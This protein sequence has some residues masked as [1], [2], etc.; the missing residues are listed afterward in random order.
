MGLLTR[1]SRAGADEPPHFP[2][3]V[4]LVLA[5]LYAVYPVL[6]VLSI[7]FSGKQSLAIAEVP[8]DPTVWDRLRAVIPW[9]AEISFSNFTAVFAD[10]PFATWVLNS[11]IVSIATTVV[12][13]F[14]NRMTKATEAI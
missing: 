13:V 6:W 14:Q 8:A 10:Q 5:T 11:A 4:L 1:K 12:G 2:M 9:P 7:A 3:H